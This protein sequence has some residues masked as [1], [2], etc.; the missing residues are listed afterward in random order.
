MSR[1]KLIAL[2]DTIL[3]EHGNSNRITF[4]D[5]LYYDPLLYALLLGTVVP[6]GFFSQFQVLKTFKVCSIKF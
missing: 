5:S 3:D 4:G 2:Y 1:K 6:Y